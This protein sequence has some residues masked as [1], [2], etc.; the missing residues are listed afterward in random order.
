MFSTDRL[1]VLWA[2]GMIEKCRYGDNGHFD[3]RVYD[4]FDRDNSTMKIGARV[5]RGK[6]V[7]RA[8]QKKHSFTS[9]M[10][11]SLPNPM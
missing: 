2:D 9:V 7:F 4:N 5:Q 6:T 1:K 3:V 10:S 8:L 11:I